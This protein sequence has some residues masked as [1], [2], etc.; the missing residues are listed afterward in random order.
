[1]DG[2]ARLHNSGVV[3]APD[4]SEVMAKAYELADA[5]RVN[6]ELGTE[7]YVVASL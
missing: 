7:K 1:M 4:I 2:V 3:N 6:I 5:N